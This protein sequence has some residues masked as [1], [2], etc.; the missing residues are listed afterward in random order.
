MNKEYLLG[1]INARL[2]SLLTHN[3]Y[4]TLKK[5]NKEQFLAYLFNT[6]VIFSKTSNFETACLEAKEV[7]KNEIFGYI[8]DKHWIYQY[9]LIKTEFLSNHYN[10]IYQSIHDDSELA[11]ITTFISKLHLIQNISLMYRLK[12]QKLDVEKLRSFLLLQNEI[13]EEFLINAYILGKQ[14]INVLVKDLLNITISLTNNT[15]EIEKMLDEYLKQL[16]M[17]YSYSV[18]FELVLIYY[19]YSV[20]KQLENVRSIYYLGGY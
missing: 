6:N 4:E 11:P 20:N 18:L 16:M 5:I 15:L 1:L 17:E 10:E 14:E 8:G 2:T 19:I 9:F 13:S 3:D 12:E 7:F